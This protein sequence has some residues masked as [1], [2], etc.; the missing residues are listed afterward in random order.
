MRDLLGVKTHRGLSFSDWAA[1]ALF[2]LPTS[3]KEQ[4]TPTE[5]SFDL[6]GD[7]NGPGSEPP[8]QDRLRLVSAVTPSRRRSPAAVGKPSSACFSAAIVTGRW[9]GPNNQRILRDA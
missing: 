6:Y 4:N 3:S 2:A 1:R 7:D 9:A 8:P 5:A